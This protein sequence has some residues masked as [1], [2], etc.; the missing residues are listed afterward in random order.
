MTSSPL[1]SNISGMVEEMRTEHNSEARVNLLFEI[2]LRDMLLPDTTAK[3]LMLN[4]PL[5]T[6]R[7]MIKQHVKL[8]TDSQLVKRSRPNILYTGSLELYS[9]ELENLRNKLRTADRSDIQHFM[10]NSGQVFFEMITYCVCKHYKTTD[11]IQILKYSLA[12]LEKITDNPEGLKRVFEYPNAVLS[13]VLAIDTNPLVSNSTEETYNLNMSNTISALNLLTRLAWRR[14]KSGAHILLD[15][16]TKVGKMRRNIGGP[17]FILS[18]SHSF[19]QGQKQMEIM[20]AVFIFLNS[21]IELED[22]IYSRTNIRQ[23]I[24]DYGLLSRAHDIQSRE[25]SKDLDSMKQGIKTELEVFEH[26][27]EQDDRQIASAPC[28]SSRTYLNN[29][30]SLWQHVVNF[31]SKNNLSEYTNSFSQLGYDTMSR[32]FLMDCE[33]FSKV[34]M[35]QGHIKEFENAVR[36]CQ[37]SSSELKPTENSSKPFAFKVIPKAAIVIKGLIG[38]GSFGDVHLAE[39]QGGQCVI[40]RIRKTAT[41]RKSQVSLS[42]KVVLEEASAMNL[43]KDHPHVIGFFGVCL[44]GSDILLV[45]EYAEL[46]SL[47]EVVVKGKPNLSLDYILKLARQG[48]SGLVHLH[49]LHVIHRD[50]ASRNFLMDSRG[51]VKVCDFGLAKVKANKNTDVSVSSKSDNPLKWAAPE[52]LS[53][54]EYSLASDVYMTGVFLWEL[55]AQETPYRELNNIQ[56]AFKVVHDNLRPSITEE[57]KSQ[58]IDLA[59]ITCKCWDSNPKNRPQMADVLDAVTTLA[60]RIGA[61]AQPY[62]QNL[63]QD[64]QSTVSKEKV[65]KPPTKSFFEMVVTKAKAYEPTSSGYAGGWK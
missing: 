24:I 59:E 9:V 55:W 7:M 27:K 11:E 26:R 39:Y 32:V 51:I 52:S 21:L 5:E 16:L 42:S 41:L 33:D 23:E 15:H 43:C 4:Q 44:D 34:A 22:D 53:C 37:Y 2:V 58:C 28:L 63:Y 45:G 62:E 14:S 8:R 31:L 49:S 36:L 56:A 13:I 1:L 10:A 46:G 47:Y 6:K 40:K 61:Q 18:C 57:M 30:D 48:V 65:L 50:I 12:C 54:R 29:Q 60:I 64:F 19:R 35:K 25:L 38:K 17:L 20:H 3:H